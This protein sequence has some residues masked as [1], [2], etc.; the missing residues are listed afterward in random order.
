MQSTLTYLNARP[1]YRSRVLG[2]LTLFIGT[3]IAGFLQIGWLAEA[4]GAPV[5]LMTTAAEGLIALLVLWLGG[6]K[7]DG[8]TPMPTPGHGSA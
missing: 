6:V 3:G 4:F 7:Y 5:A 8:S 2:V 1:E